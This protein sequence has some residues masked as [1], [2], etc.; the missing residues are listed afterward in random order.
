MARSRIT[1]INAQ[2]IDDRPLP[3]VWIEYKTT[4]TEELR[5]K[6]MEHFLPLV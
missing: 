3:Q 5:N 2:T 6:L 4:G 1:A